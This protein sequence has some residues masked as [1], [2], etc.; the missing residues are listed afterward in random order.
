MSSPTE[1]I[2][3]SADTENDSELNLTEKN[4][5]LPLAIAGSLGG[6]CN[7]GIELVRPTQEKSDKDFI[8]GISLGMGY[9]FF[10]YLLLSLVVSSILAPTTAMFSIGLPNT[11][12]FN[13][14]LILS[15]LFGA[16]LTV[17]IETALSNVYITQKNQ[18]V[19]Q[20][21]RKI[22]N[23]FQQLNTEIN[24]LD[25][26]VNTDKLQEKIEGKEANQIK[27]IPIRENIAL[28]T[29]ALYLQG[30]ISDNDTIIKNKIERLEELKEE[31]QNVKSDDK[32]NIDNLVKNIE[33]KVVKLKEKS[34]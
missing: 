13:R 15:A 24:N 3:T 2:S 16:F 8:P 30:K 9:E 29:D 19:M 32:D 6:L 23:A 7:V 17:T 25:A 14:I 21:N 22:Q 5:Y 11:K 1:K 33:D 28:K 12:N 18:D 20:K 31:V 10:I 27:E 4:V 26:K 34:E